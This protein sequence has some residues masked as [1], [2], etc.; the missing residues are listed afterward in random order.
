MKNN[1]IWITGASGFTGSHAIAVKERIDLL[2]LVTIV[3]PFY[4]DPFIGEAI[5]SALNQSYSRIEVIVVDDGSTSYQNLID[6]YRGRIHYLGKSNGGTA[7]AINHGIRL[8]SG[9]YIAWLSSD[10]QFHP[11]KIKNQMMFMLQHKSS[12]SFT[13]FHYMNAQNAITH[14]NAAAIFSTVKGFYQS[15][16]SFNPINGCTVVI[17][18]S[19]A[20]QIGLFN[21]YL[22]YTH[23]YD[24]WV[25]IILSKTDLHFLNQSLT[26][27]RR[28]DQMGTIQHQQKIVQEF[29]RIRQQYQKPLQRF[30]NQM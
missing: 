16:L 30:L 24:L 5:S 19:Y 25:R 15:F 20:L 13:N 2:P 22:P 9:D 18:K 10:D 14:A 11:D 21:E 4:N 3:I 6:P 23:D 29:H 27:Y 1:R 26:F 12:F 17:S 28:H 7:S 8:A